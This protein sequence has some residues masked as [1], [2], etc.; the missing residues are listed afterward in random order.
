MTINPVS[1]D[2][3]GAQVN[4]M[5]AEVSESATTT[6]QII[7]ASAEVGNSKLFDRQTA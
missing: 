1:E 7:D 5:D 6:I 2:L 3:N 4:F